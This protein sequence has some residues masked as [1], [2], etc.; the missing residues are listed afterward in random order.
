VSALEKGLNSDK[1]LKRSNKYLRAKY[2]QDPN[3]PHR[4]ICNDCLLNGAKSD[5]VSGR[6]LSQFRKE[7]SEKIHF[8]DEVHQLALK[9]FP[10]RTTI[11]V[12]TNAELVAQQNFVK[13]AKQAPTSSPLGSWGTTKSS[14]I[15]Q[16]ATTTSTTSTTS[17]S[18]D[19]R[20][21]AYLLL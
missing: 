1:K 15:P 2:T 6:H 19:K 4:Y 20:D 9:L 5:E 7:H 12:R 18:D 8:D 11:K 10:R 14:G 16:R 13:S 3:N 21:Y 17:T